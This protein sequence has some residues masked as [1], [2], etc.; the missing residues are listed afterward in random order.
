MLNAGRGLGAKDDT[1]PRRWFEEPNTAGP[2]QGETI[3]REAFEALKQR[4]YQLSGLEADG[5]PQTPWWNKLS[6]V[7]TGY[8]V[9]VSWPPVPGLQRRSLVINRPLLTL[10]EVREY[11]SRLLPEMGPLLDDKATGIAINDQ[12]V[13]SSEADARINNGDQISIVPILSGG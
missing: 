1:L 2:F 6:A 4:F 3:D 7:L 13:I 12:L 9:Y 5:L 10:P 11:I 8:A